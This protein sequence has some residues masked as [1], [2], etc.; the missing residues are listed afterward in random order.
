MTDSTT[1]HPG[2]LATTAETAVSP[3]A[4]RRALPPSVRQAA[5]VGGVLDTS[6]SPTTRELGAVDAAH[7]AI[8][9]RAPLPIVTRTSATTYGG[10][11]ADPVDSQARMM[12]T[13]GTNSAFFVA[14]RLGELRSMLTKQDAEEDPALTAMND[15][16][17]VIAAVA[18]TNE[19]EA[20]LATQ[21]AGTHVLS[22]ELMSR[23]MR[24]ANPEQMNALVNSAT[25][26]QRTFTGQIE[27]L[28]R[29]RGKGQQ[30]VRV[31][32]VT[33]EAG[34]QAIVGDV[35]HHSTPKES[36]HV[37]AARVGACTSLS[38]TNA[39]RDGMSVTCHEERPVPHARRRQHRN[40]SRK[41]E[42]S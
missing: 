11:D 40:S 32:H 25:K 24:M 3:H 38:G 35:H 7:E 1:S 12:A 22:C 2:D 19:L 10:L 37:E 27:A 6:G 28:A 9:S 14:S 31:E 23:A 13:M 39:V 4:S 21:M 34:A 26:L 16:V 36:H 41:P 29:L 18:P 8:H 20:M 30:T 17:A 33:V 15:G 42:R 5:L